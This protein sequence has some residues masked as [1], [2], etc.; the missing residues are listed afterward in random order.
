MVKDPDPINEGL[1]GKMF[2][3]KKKESRKGLKRKLSSQESFFLVR[4]KTWRENLHLYWKMKQKAKLWH[5]STM[6]EYF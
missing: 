2:F 6:L 1:P 3:S 4:A 5:E